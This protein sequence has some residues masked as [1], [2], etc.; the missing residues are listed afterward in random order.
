MNE[1]SYLYKLT[2]DA[3][4]PI[5]LSLLL[6]AILL[7]IVTRVARVI[8]KNSLKATKDPSK[9]LQWDVKE[10]ALLY[11]QISR[12]IGILSSVLLTGYLIYIGVKGTPMLGHLMEW[13]NIIVRWGHVVAGVMWIGA[14]FYFVFLENNLNRT[15]GI[16]DELA[17]NLWAIHGGGFYF[18][19]KYKVAPKEIPKD[20]HWFKYEAYFTWAT[21]FALLWVVYYMDADALLIDKTKVDLSPAAAI[22]IGISTLVGGWILYAALCKMLMN[23]PKVL[24]I[25]GFLCLVAIAYFL[26]QVFS[27]RAAY[28]HVGALI[29]TIM[30]WNVYFIIIPGQKAMV[31]AAFMG[32][33]VDPTHGKK[34]L[35][36]SLHNNYLTLPV[37]FIMISN[38][39]PS[40]FGNDYSW[41]ILIVISLASAGI[42]HYWNL[43]EKGQRSRYILPVSVVAMISLVYFTKPKMEALDESIAQ[44]EFSE[45]QSIIQARCVQCHSSVPTDDKWTAAPNGVMYDTP[46]QIKQYAQKIMIRAVQTKTMPQG[47]KTGMLESEREVLK[48]WILQGAKIDE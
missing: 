18:L 35:Q 16:R 12:V 27:S 40:T 39:F 28:I 8:T 10:N 34:A 21:G 38:H 24:G 26:T 6:L 33:P 36:R 3:Q 22:T 37:I 29:G 5:A 30:A 47:N 19:E 2:S 14:S 11:L 42:K 25:V 48:N 41:L 43:I 32:L 23:R 45:V 13:L 46:E 1:L 20:L 9:E 44:V 31:K 17:G 4:F 15:K 7:F